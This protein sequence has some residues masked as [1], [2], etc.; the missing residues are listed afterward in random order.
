MFSL[1]CVY[2]L[3]WLFP[4]LTSRA[5]RDAGSDLVDSL[6]FLYLDS[7]ILNRFSLFVPHLD[8]YQS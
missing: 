3:F 6:S 2:L 1:H 7:C 4:I 8:L 5:E